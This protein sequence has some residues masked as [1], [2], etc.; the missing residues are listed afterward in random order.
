VFQLWIDSA[1][2]A[3]RTGLNWLGAF[4]AYGINAVYFENYWNAGAPQA[5]ERYFDNVVVSTQ[6]IGC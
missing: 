4:S 3:E 6:R 5:E 2:E 1:L